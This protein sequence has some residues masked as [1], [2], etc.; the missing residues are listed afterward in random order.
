MVTRIASDEGVTSIQ[1]PGLDQTIPAA[2]KWNYTAVATPATANRSIAY[3][4]G[5][6]LGGTS[7]ISEYSKL[8][9]QS[10]RSIAFA[11]NLL[12]GMAYTRCSQDDYNTW[13]TLTG[14]DGWRWDNLWPLML[15]VCFHSYVPIL[16]QSSFSRTS[17]WFPQP[18]VAIPQETSTLRSTPPTELSKSACLDL[19]LLISTT[20]S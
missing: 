19:G 2:Y 18:R 3:P 11:D 7:S 10:L 4:R 17:D 8:C 9:Q 6:V 20:G 16:L 15:R 1:A 13:A 5:Y 14:D 12:D